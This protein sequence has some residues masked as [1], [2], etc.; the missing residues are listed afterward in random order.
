MR[1]I[2]SDSILSDLVL[3]NSSLMPVIYLTGVCGNFNGKT[4]RQICKEK[5]INESYLLNLL[6][7]FTDENY[8][9]AETLPSYGV[10]QLTALS[11]SI[12]QFFLNELD[13]LVSVIQK[14]VKGEKFPHIEKVSI[15]SSL[16]GCFSD[17]R[18]LLSNRSNQHVQLV[19][20][21]VSTVYELYYSPD[22]TSERT[23]LLNYSLEF[24]DSKILVLQHSFEGVKRLLEQI[25]QWNPS[26]LKLLMKVYA[27]YQ[28]NRNIVSQ[29]RIEQKLLKPLVLQMEESVILTFH[30]KNKKIR[31]NN[32][33]SLPTEISP[34]D[35]L[36]PREKEVL[37]LVAQG[38]MNKE[39]ADQLH[40]G[41]TTVITHRKKM[42]EKLGIKTIPGL[43]VYA[44]T[45]GYLDELILTKED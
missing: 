45:Q 17:Y 15:A 40:I 6:M 2:S 43:T 20:P 28:L 1:K 37:K 24:Y 31:R 42:V 4:I 27:F 35:V 10:L 23:D 29:D 26:D 44:F 14:K 41:L 30:K 11:T 16:K 8:V 19:L 36:T 3:Q 38:F 25:L 21:H 22:Y 7:A 34:S 33:V 32:Y 39:I 12:Y 5:A 18:Q 13:E 9:P